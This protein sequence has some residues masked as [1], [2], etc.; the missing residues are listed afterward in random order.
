MNSY[1]APNKSN[2]TIGITIGLWLLALL[3]MYSGSDTEQTTVEHASTI[4]PDS[5]AN[6]FDK[7]AMTAKIIPSQNTEHNVIKM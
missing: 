5:T 7:I 6:R 2:W 4:D 1:Q 3:F